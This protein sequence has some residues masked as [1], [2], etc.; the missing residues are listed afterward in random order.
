M[1]ARIRNIVTQ[2]LVKAW[3][4]LSR[5]T[6]DYRR[7]D[8]TWQ[9]LHREV[10]D[11]GNAACILM[12]NPQTRKVLLTRQFR[13]P[14]T[15]NGDHG[16]LIECC[17][18][19]LDDDEPLAAIMREAMEETGYRPHG[20]THLYDAYM[21]PGS[22]TEKLSFFIGLYD[23]NSRQNA[24]GGLPEEGEEIEVL[25]MDLATALDLIA[26]GKIIDAK[27]IALLHWAAWNYPA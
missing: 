1:D 16:W 5:A 13:Y 2:T 21:S 8:G 25:E 7:N 26:S 23:D 6:F 9:T 20:V 22:L 3:G 17:A 15:L 27:T 12:I 4:T 24:G 18:G 11:H 14:P 19:L 10:Y